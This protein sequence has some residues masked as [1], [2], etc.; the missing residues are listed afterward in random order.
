[1]HSLNSIINGLVIKQ[2]YMNKIAF[3]LFL[4][5]IMHFSCREPV[6]KPNIIM[7]MADDLG[8]AD[9]GFN[10][11]DKVR[12]PQLDALAKQGIILDR[13]YAAS[14]VCSPTRA[15]CLTGRHPHRLGITNA[16]T[17]H[18]TKEEIT[19]PEILKKE[20]YF[21]GHF[22]KWHLGTLTTKEKDSNRGRPGEAKH[23]SIPTMHGYDKFFCTEA[24]VPTYDPLVRPLKFDSTQSESLRYGWRAL[25]ENEGRINYGTNYWIAEET[26]VLDNVEGDDSKIIMD[27][28][29]PF[30]DEAV[31]NESPFFT[32]IWFHSPHLPVV[33]DKEMRA[34]Y[35][36]FSLAEQLY[37][38]T[39]SGL[40]QQV[41]RLWQYLKTLEIADNT[42][43]WFCSDNG[44]E[45]N[46]PG[47]AGP[48]RERKRSLY[49]GGV[50]VPAF[51][52]WKDHWN[53][54]VRLEYPM[55]TSDYLPTI[56]D[57]L[58]INGLFDRSIDGI[59]LQ[60]GLC[61]ENN[62]REEPIGFLYQKRMSWVNQQYKLI[63]VDAGLTYELYDLILD[64]GEETD[65]AGHYPEQVDK[66][67]KALLDWSHTVKSEAMSDQ[68]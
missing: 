53:G 39:I 24:K 67:K 14:P 28:V 68:D 65:L 5:I 17:G 26:L 49:E 43:I 13:F 19:L 55:V 27:R 44:P 64:P 45:N 22:G 63:S 35:P 48:F 47:S 46:T 54:G 2:F 62:V 41:G 29:L 10:G 16:N 37:Y 31:K 57:L 33:A 59:S 12:S 38:G 6:R 1:M 18:L 15:S 4:T 25:E 8:W 32:T 61:G 23:Y 7:I 58:G 56:L 11:A 30:V 50:R 51:V 36:S 40:D 20:G 52:V 9:V 42:L 34:L 66:L 60:K 21:T 3:L